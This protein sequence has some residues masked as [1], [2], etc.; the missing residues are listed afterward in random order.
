M[1]VAVTKSCSTFCD[2]MNC[3]TLGSCPPTSP[4]VCSN[5]VHWVGDAVQP[6]CPLSSPS[7]F[8]FNLSQHSGLFQRIFASGDQSIGVSASALVLPMYIQGWFPLELTGLISLLPKG[9]S[10]AF[11]ST[12]ILKYQF[13]G[14]QPSTWSN[15]HIHTWLLEKPYLWLD[16]P[17]LAKGCLCFLICC[18]GLS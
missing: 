2:P 3:S 17:L 13:F 11:S 14:T 9:L 7:P 6:S 18:L 8:A 10:R 1:Q 4:G 15:S 12:T 5:H 16:R